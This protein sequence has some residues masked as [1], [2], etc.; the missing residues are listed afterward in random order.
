METNKA[1]IA[2]VLALG[3]AALWIGGVTLGVAILAKVLE[4]LTEMLIGKD[5]RK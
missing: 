2:M 1:L 3:F 4:D 5:T